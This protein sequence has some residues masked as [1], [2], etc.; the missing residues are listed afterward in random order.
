MEFLLEVEGLQKSFGGVAAL[1]DGRFQLRA[2]SVHALCGGNGAGKSTFLKIL[3]GIH[4]RDAGLIRRRG[5]EVDYASPAEAL[6]AGIAIIEQELSPIP[7]MTVAENIYLGR[8]PSARFGGIDF[9]TMNRSAQALLDRLEFNIRATQFMMNLSVAQV[10]L[11]EIAKALSHDAEVIFMDEPTSAIGEKEA[12]Q[13]FSTIERLKAEGKGIVYVSHR[14]SE[15]FQIADSYTA[16]RDGS[17]VGSGAIADID[18]AGLIRM[19]V[20]RELGEEYIKTNTPTATAGFEVSGLTAPGKIDD[21]SFVARKG[22]IFGIYGLMGSGRTEIFDCI[23]GLDAPT[24]GNM[25]L[26][27][28]SISVRKPAE[29]MQHGIAFVT[30]DRKLTGLNLSDSVRNNICLASLPEMSPQFS[31]DRRAEAAASAAMIERF[32]IKAARDSMAVSGLSGGNQQK[33]VLGK[34]FLR[35][36]KVLLLD[37]PTR[38]VDVGAKR[39]IYRIICDFAAEGGTV[40]MISSEIDEVLGM[41]DRILVMRQGRSAG[42]L[43]R[44]EADAQALVHLST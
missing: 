13:L 23:F 33:V 44:K 6:A 4:A 37:E 12:Q 5:K 27:G 29:A 15:I 34:W 25:K 39:E 18:R 36:P 19:I 38:G 2:G 7:H 21:I 41:S 11:V 31:M 42:I 17:Y 3:M 1:R 9:K 28:Q 30:E 10:Q 20:G 8:E 22:E 24:S 14:L 40:I 35:K 16:F 32:G 26:A 43:E